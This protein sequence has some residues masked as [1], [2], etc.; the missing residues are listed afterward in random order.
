MPPSLVGGRRAHQAANTLSQLIG[1]T[2]QDAPQDRPI[3]TVWRIVSSCQLI[4]LLP[5]SWCKEPAGALV[6]ECRK[7]EA[8]GCK[9]LV[10]GRR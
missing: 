6:G 4:C 10:T 9:R 3:G 7:G 5:F 2:L 8:G 1:T